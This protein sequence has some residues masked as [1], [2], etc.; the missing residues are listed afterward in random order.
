MG[1]RKVSAK[2]KAKAQRRP[3][4]QDQLK[5]GNFKLTKPKEKKC[6]KPPKIEPVTVLDQIKDKQHGKDRLKKPK[7]KKCQKPKQ[8]KT[9][10]PSVYDKITDKRQYLT[11]DEDDDDEENSW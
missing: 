1:S 4:L 11:D 3:S 2:A 7:E 8:P 9:K 6:Q 10:R 5:S